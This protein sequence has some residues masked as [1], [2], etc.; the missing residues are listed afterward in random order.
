MKYTYPIV[1]T[2][3]PDSSSK[4]PYIVRIPD[5]D[6]LTQGESITDAIEM[7]QDLLSIL[8]VQ[9]EDEKRELPEA[10]PFADLS[11]Q[12]RG[13][14]VSLVIADS[15]HYRQM[16]QSKPVKKTLAIPSWLNSRAEEAGINFSQTLQDALKAK[17]L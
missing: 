8:V 1:I 15:D 14:V 7:G 17:L 6:A 11:E 5:F 13:S 12:F 3:E 2:H 16:H 9:Y 4:A 10:S